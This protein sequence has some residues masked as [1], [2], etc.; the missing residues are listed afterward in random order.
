LSGLVIYRPRR[1]FW[2]ERPYGG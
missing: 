2:S 1:V